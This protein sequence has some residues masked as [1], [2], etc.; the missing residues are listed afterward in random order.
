MVE[1]ELPGADRRGRQPVERPVG[2]A[3]LHTADT[4]VGDFRIELGGVSFPYDRFQE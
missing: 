1:D 3:A 2:F 4:L